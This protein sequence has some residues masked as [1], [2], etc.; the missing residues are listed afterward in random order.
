MFGPDEQHLVVMSQAEAT[1]RVYDARTRKLLANHKIAGFEPGKWMRGEVTSWPD[2]ATPGFLVGNSEGLRLYDLIAGTEV[3]R[4]S[5]VSTWSLRWSPDRRFLVAAEMDLDRQVSRLRFYARAARSLTK[6]AEFETPE[7]IDAIALSPDNRR[8]AVVTYPNDH[9]ELYDLQSG[10]K[11]WSIAAPAYAGTVDISPDGTAVAVGGAEV[12]IVG[13]AD[14]SDP[15]Y[16]ASYTKL[17]NNAHRVRFSPSG[18]ALVATAYDGH[19]RI[20]S[21]DA[22]P[23]TLKLLK[24][25]RHS[26]T[27][28][29]YAADFLED[30][31]GLVTS[32]GDRSVRLWG[33]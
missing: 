14:P 27:A 29:V 2:P 15:A 31:S 24:D 17:G 12:W 7:R 5:A 32:S 21:S 8:A 28:N 13:A 18:D 10:Q 26:G 4:F 9:F 22:G 6:I 25:L 19:A 23:S 30:G 33:R 16:R 1:V 11:L 20:L 3:E